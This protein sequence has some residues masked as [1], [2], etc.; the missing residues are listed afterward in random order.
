M[1]RL[2]RRPTMRDLWEPAKWQE[3][4]REDI[5]G[6]KEAEDGLGNARNKE[7]WPRRAPVCQTSTQADWDVMADTARSAA[8]AFCGGSNVSTST[9][10]GLA[11]AAG[12]WHDFFMGRGRALSDESGRRERLGG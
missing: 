11:Q 4:A 7:A 12:S 5:S 8:S 3:G 2:D 9:C 6:Q 10:H 1:A